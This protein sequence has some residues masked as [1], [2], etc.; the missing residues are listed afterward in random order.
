MREDHYDLTSLD[1]I[2]RE[3]GVIDWNTTMLVKPG[4]IVIEAPKAKPDGWSSDYYI[5]PEGAKELGDLI[6][7]KEMNFNV[8]NMFKACYRLGN[9]PGVSALYDL[10]KIKWFV[11]RE[12]ARV[13]K[14]K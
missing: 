11:E 9:K 14:M 1:F 6:E 13:E 7:Y 3:F 5:I 8:G 10:K 2:D 12:I 4:T